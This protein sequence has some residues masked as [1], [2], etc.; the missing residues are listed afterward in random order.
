[1][2]GELYLDVTINGAAMQQIA[3]FFVTDQMIYTTRD[4]LRDL[5]IRTDDPSTDASGRIALGSVPGLRYTYRPERQR[6]DLEVADARR[7]PAA[8]ANAQPRPPLS[9][10]GT[11]LVINYDFTAQTNLPTQYGLYTEQRLFYPGGIFD[12]TGTAYWYASQHRYVRLDTSWSHSSPDSLLTTRLG[13]TISS[14][15]TWTRPVRRVAPRC[16]AISA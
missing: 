8:L 10:S 13:D 12:N 11:G 9:A 16:R 6:L 7:I 14:S 3:H 4:E 15:L 2:R 5:G 1:M